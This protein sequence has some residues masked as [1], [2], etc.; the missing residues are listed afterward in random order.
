MCCL[1]LT[2]S[3][4]SDRAPDLC[5]IIPVAFSTKVSI[6]FIKYYLSSHFHYLIWDI[7]CQDFKD[8]VQP[9]IRWITNDTVQVDDIVD[10]NNNPCNAILLSPDV[11]R[12]LDDLKWCLYVPDKTKPK[13]LV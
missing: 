7:Q 3:Q 13:A 11:H 1:T 6:D 4:E 5:H 8:T 9:W 12:A 2:E 10:N